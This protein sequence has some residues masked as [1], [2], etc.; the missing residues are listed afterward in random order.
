MRSFKFGKRNFCQASWFTLRYFKKKYGG[1]LQVRQ[2][3][4]KY[5]W[6]L[7]VRQV[8]MKFIKLIYRIQIN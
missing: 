5:E 7:Q 2:V 1:L 3:K 6:L 4:M 8:K